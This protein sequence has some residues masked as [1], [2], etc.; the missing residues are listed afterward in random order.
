VSYPLAS[1]PSGSGRPTVQRVRSGANPT[2]QRSD[3][4]RKREGAPPPV[5]A[6]PSS[7]CAA[8]AP[9]QARAGFRAD[10]HADRHER[11]SLGGVGQADQLVSTSARLGSQSTADYGAIAPRVSGCGRA[12]CGARPRAAMLRRPRSQDPPHCGG[13]DA[14]GE[15]DPATPAAGSPDRR[16]LL[17]HRNCR[18]ACGVHAE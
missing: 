4:A 17:H 7:P 13:D 14:G 5:V 18:S 9:P 11:S 1:G 8:E 10:P 12:A 2:R 16:C 6:P 15:A 3:Q